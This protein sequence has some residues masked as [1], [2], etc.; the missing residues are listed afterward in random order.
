MSCRS[1]HDLSSDH[2]PIII[3]LH[4]IAQ[5]RAQK[6]V[7]HNKRTNWNLFRELTDKAF[8][9]PI[10]LKTNEEI[11]EAVMYFNYTVQDAAWSSTPPPAQKGRTT[12]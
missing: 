6:C 5:E 11:S 10:S 7:L 12:L 9:E 8:Q 1:C 2:S 3:E 4:T